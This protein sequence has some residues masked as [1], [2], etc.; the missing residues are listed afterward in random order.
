M[1]LAL[2]KVSCENEGSEEE[3]VTV[4]LV[5]DLPDGRGIT[6][7]GSGLLTPIAT[8]GVRIRIEFGHSVHQGLVVPTDPV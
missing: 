7:C 2:A 8:F 3:G 4:M 5:S 1:I 6:S